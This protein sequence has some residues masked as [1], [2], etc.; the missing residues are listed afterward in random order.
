MFSYKK[1]S[2]L[3]GPNLTIFPVPAG[4][5]TELGWIPLS[6]SLSVGSDHNISTTSCYS[7]FWT[8]CITSKGLCNY[9]IW[10]KLANEEPIPP[11]IHKI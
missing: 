1:F 3:S 2:T 5:L 6:W 7:S 8:S 9:K 10:F 4:S 11:W